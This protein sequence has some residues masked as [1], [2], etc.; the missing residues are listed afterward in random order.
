MVLGCA[1]LY[2]AFAGLQSHTTDS[3]DVRALQS[4]FNFK[5]QPCLI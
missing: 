5:I 3:F 2:A 1:E 4:P